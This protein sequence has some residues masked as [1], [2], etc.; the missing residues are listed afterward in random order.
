MRTKPT[1]A[2][3]LLLSASP[4]FGDVKLPAIFGDHMVLQRDAKVPVWGSADAGEAVTVTAGNAKAQATAGADGKW[5]ATLEGLKASDQPIDITVAGKNTITLHDVLV[6]DVW[7]CSGQSN[8]EFQLGGGKAYGFG[9]AHNSEEEIPKADHPTL[10]LFIVKKKVA[11]DPQTDCG[12]EWKLCVPDSAGHF[13]AVGYFFGRDIQEDQKVPVGMIGTYWGGTPAEAWTSLEALKAVPDLAPAAKRF[14]DT[15]AN[16]DSLKETYEKETLP[17]WQEAD[18]EWKTK[19]LAPY[20]VKLENWNIFVAKTG[21]ENAP[22]KPEL[23]QQEPRRPAAPD[24]N[25]NLPTVLTNGMIAPIVPYAIK[26]AIWY[27]GE[28]NAGQAKLYQTLFPTM[29]TDWRTRWAEGDFP[30]IWVQLANYQARGN[31]PTQ[32]PDGWPGLRE[33]QSMTL[34]LPN[35][36]EAVIIDIGQANDIHPKDKLD[37]GH[38]LSLAARHVAYGEDLVYSGPTYDSMKVEGDKIRI[39]FKNIG[40]GLTIAANPSTQPGVPPAEPASELKGFS[41]A[42][43]DQKFVWA[44]ATIDGD[45]V[46]V[47][48]PDVKEPQAV[49]YGWAN[50]PEVNLYNKDGLPAS[51][52]RTDDWTGFP[53]SAAHK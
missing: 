41:I 2:I 53:A 17:K 37:V 9:G 31:Q 38:R 28:S 48:S 30:F 21:G 8:M 45:S 13:S 27:Q 50:N 29:I 23:L 10:R 44:T 49:R 32:S 34:K 24:N 15:K 16:L 14:E 26:G 43:A 35:T 52:F 18:N 46:V 40:A 33:A 39:S 4:L 5:T 12:G 51:P 11:F 19:V 7:V 25:P 20:K 3:L 47:S 1:A 6:G 42:G 36:G 22:A